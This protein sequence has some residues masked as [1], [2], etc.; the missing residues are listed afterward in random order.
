MIP[1]IGPPTSSAVEGPLA[2]SPVSAGAT[3]DIA[4]TIGTPV[5]GAS[6]AG[7]A[8]QPFAAALREALQGGLTAGTPRDPS[9]A[10]RGDPVTFAAEI[11]S[12]GQASTASGSS[13][14]P[15]SGLSTSAPASS[16]T[17]A[18]AM[19]PI[20]FGSWGAGVPDY[21]P[22]VDSLNQHVLGTAW[23][24]GTAPDGAPLFDAMLQGAQQGHDAISWLNPVTGKREM[25][26]TNPAT[27]ART[28]ANLTRE[29]HEGTLA[30]WQASPGALGIASPGYMTT[31]TTDTTDPSTG[32]VLR[33][34]VEGQPFSGSAATVDGKLFSGALGQAPG[35]APAGGQAAPQATPPSAG[36]SSQAQSSSTQQSRSLTEQGQSAASTASAQPTGSPTGSTQA[37]VADLLPPAEPSLGGMLL[38]AFAPASAPAGGTPPS[39][40]SRASAAAPAV[41]PAPASSLQLSNHASQRL[42]QRGV[43]LGDAEK[44]RL[45][46]ALD[47]L[48]SKGAR[49]SLV[50]LE[51]VAYVVHVPSQTVVTAL[52]PTSGKEAVF[53]KIDSAVVA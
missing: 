18:P 38:D 46:Q 30:S 5:A 53:T 27:I 31:T 37:Q 10:Q 11:A 25:W 49:T 6:G 21:S 19:P 9:S 50:M 33:N 12:A 41:A 16:A 2:S 32:Q 43:T 17:S 3:A 52:R 40:P 15:A 51:G 35:T 44:N 7:Q 34:T 22:A 29:S 24:P 20:S 28:R 42:D 47:T 36:A 45:L 48:A 26:A 8:S 13:A 23:N 4:P 39:S 1:Q 14:T